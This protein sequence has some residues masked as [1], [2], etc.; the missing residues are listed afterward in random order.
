MLSDAELEEARQGVREGLRGP[1]VVKWLRQLL[2]DREEL[3]A[4]LQTLEATQSD[5]RQLK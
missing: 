2:E 1:V 4:R 5:L 3:L